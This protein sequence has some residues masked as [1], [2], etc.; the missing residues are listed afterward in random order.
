MG[1]LVMEPTVCQRCHVLM[2]LMWRK[3]NV[4]HLWPFVCSSFNEI[5]RFWKRDTHAQGHDRYRI[6]I[7]IDLHYRP[8]LGSAVEAVPV[9][10]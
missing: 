10:E 6:D 3:G 2:K 4:C 1:F 9:G 8:L 7:A 5:T